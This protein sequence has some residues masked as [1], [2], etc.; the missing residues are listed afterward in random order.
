[1][2]N[3]EKNVCQIIPKVFEGLRESIEERNECQKVAEEIRNTYFDGKPFNSSMMNYLHV[4][5]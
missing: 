1:M 2:D 4:R 3:V 5:G